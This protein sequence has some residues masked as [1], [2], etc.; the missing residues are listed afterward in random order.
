MGNAWPLFSPNRL[1]R[2]RTS[3]FRSTTANNL[4]ANELEE[5]KAERG[6]A[7][8]SWLEGPEMGTC[9]ASP[10]PSKSLFD[11]DEKSSG[12]HIGDDGHAATPLVLTQSGMYGVFELTL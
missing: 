11:P 1:T 2:R 3:C 8:L 9:A 12:K 6:R 4:N 10:P 5:E 7:S